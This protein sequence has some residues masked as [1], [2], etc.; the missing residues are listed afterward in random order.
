MVDKLQLLRGLPTMIISSDLFRLTPAELRALAD[1]YEKA[2]TPTPSPESTPHG[3]HAGADKGAAHRGASDATGRRDRTE[4]PIL[5]LADSVRP[6]RGKSANESTTADR[7]LPIR[8]VVPES[9]AT[10]READA[11][12]KMAPHRSPQ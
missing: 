5:A 7:R 4:S 10:A 2:W 9:A 6:R 8:F 12:E 3:P 1:L 11:G